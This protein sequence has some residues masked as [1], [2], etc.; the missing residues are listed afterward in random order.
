MTEPRA[1]DPRFQVPERRVIALALFL[2]AIF[3]FARPVMLPFVVGALIAYAFS[4]YIDAAQARTG[5]SRLL[6]VVAG[7][8][9]ALLL[10]GL[11]VVAFS[12]HVHGR[13]DCRPRPGRHHGVPPDARGRNPGRRG[14]APRRA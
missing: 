8:G 13:G 2:A 7:Y 5:R 1:V 10:V 11:V 14:P 6:I 9:A 4:P 12:G 3:W